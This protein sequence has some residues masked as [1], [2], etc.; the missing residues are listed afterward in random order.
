[1]SAD[2]EIHAKQIQKTKQL[3]AK[4][5]S[6]NCGQ[7]YERVL[8]DLERDYWLDAKE[9]IEYGIVDHILENSLSEIG[10]V[11]PQGKKK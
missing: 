11:M 4:I 2:L 8:R 7:D 1:M 9:A 6:E 3:G 10:D 5:L